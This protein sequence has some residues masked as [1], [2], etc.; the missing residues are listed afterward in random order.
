MEVKAQIKEWGNSY[1]IRIS[2][3]DVRKLGIVKGE[4]VHLKISKNEYDIDQFI[5]ICRGA[6]PF[7]REKED[8]Y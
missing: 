6:K 1:G 3:S 2:K 4:T 8:R 7:I 5:G